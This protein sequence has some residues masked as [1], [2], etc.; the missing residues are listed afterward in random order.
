MKV[1]NTQKDSQKE[2]DFPP[3][4]AMYHL[5]ASCT[6]FNT[7]KVNTYFTDISMHISQGFCSS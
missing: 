6:N 1:E 2:N 5:N 3:L 7:Q 4:T